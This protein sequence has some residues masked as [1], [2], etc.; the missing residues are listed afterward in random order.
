MTELENEHQIFILGVLVLLLWIAVMYICSSPQWL[1]RIEAYCLGNDERLTARRASWKRRLSRK[2]RAPDVPEIIVEGEQSLLYFGPAPIP[3]IRVDK[4]T[5]RRS[6]SLPNV[7]RIR[8]VSYV[9]VPKTLYRRVGSW[10]WFWTIIGYSY[11]IFWYTLLLLAL[12]FVRVTYYTK[13][14]PLLRRWKKRA[15]C[16]ASERWVQSLI[17]ILLAYSYSYFMEN[18]LISPAAKKL[19]KS[20]ANNGKRR[21]WATYVLESCDAHTIRTNALHAVNC[22][23]MKF[24]PKQGPRE[25]ET[26]GKTCYGKSSFAGALL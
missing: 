20:K 2:T 18:N 11:V 26:I 10:M 1:R 24:K 17:H 19:S 21:H 16:Q 6:I 25:H 22:L 4:S 8:H 9:G 12:D 5:L 15:A 3:V 13:R 23:Y 7:G 14:E